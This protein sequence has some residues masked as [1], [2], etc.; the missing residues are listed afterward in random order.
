VSAGLVD[1]WGTC[2]VVAK[3]R[4]PLELGLRI[5][6]ANSSAQNESE[7]IVPVKLNPSIANSLR[8]YASEPDIAR[9]LLAQRQVIR[10]L[11]VLALE[12]SLTL[13]DDRVELTIGARDISSRA[14]VIALREA[15][16]VAYELRRRRTEFPRSDHEDL[17]RQ[18]WIK[19]ASARGGHFD[20]TGEALTFDSFAGEVRMKIEPIDAH[21]RGWRT[22]LVLTFKRPLQPVPESADSL[23]KQLES[24]ACEVELDPRHLRARVAH[25]LHDEDELSKILEAL[26]SAGV[27]IEQE[28]EAGRRAYR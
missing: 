5:V 6:A 4:R 23:L 22:N 11:R 15:S 9:Q 21:R 10:S 26:V 16:T 12:G 7:N 3:F 13:D 24:L 19:Q 2:V 28:A 27:A 25:P 8:A 14:V 17:V 20:P 18:A 1:G